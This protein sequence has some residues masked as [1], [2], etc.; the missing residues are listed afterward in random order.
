MLNS[1]IIYIKKVFKILASTTKNLLVLNAGFA[2]GLIT[3]LIPALSGLNPVANPDEPLR[4][5]NEQ[6][7]W[8]GI[9]IY[10]F[11]LKL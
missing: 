9:L 1:I 8:I 10:F 2:L 7:S 4:I 11:L 5:T 6:A 3:V